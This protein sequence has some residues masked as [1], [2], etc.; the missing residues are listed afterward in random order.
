MPG[1]EAGLNGDH[2]TGYFELPEG[3]R[4]I[5]GAL[6]S[7]TSD[8]RSSKYFPVLWYPFLL[9]GGSGVQWGGDSTLI[10]VNDEKSD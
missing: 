5:T 6:K 2:F 7:L 3:I 10:E 1:T 9:V 4:K 8:C